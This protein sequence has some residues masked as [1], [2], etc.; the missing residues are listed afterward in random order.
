[1]T[2]TA[3][4]LGTM[5]LVEGPVQ[6]QE[7]AERGRHLRAVDQIPAGKRVLREE[8]SAAVLYDDQVSHR[9]HLTFESVQS[10]LRCGG[11]KHARYAS[12]ANQRI[13]WSTGHRQECAALQACHPEVPPPTVRLIA[14]LFWRRERYIVTTPRNACL[15]Q[16]L[17][18]V[19]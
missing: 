17:T 14:R 13:A 8:T 15:L 7:A 5:R 9:C 10:P 3:T 18:L 19:L 1:M 2:D 11:C 4:Q 16:H 12:K 6:Q